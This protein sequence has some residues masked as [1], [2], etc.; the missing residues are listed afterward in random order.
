M[1]KGFTADWFYLTR[2]SARAAR[3]STMR[4]GLACSRCRGA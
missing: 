2:G 4:E 1:E 3:R